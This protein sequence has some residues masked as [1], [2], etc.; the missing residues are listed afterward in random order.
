[1][2]NKYLKK[3]LFWLLI[4]FSISCNN[5][6]KDEITYEVKNYGIEYIVASPIM[7]TST[8]KNIKEKTIKNL[9]IFEVKYIDKNDSITNNFALIPDIEQPLI[10]RV[11][12]TFDNSKKEMYKFSKPYSNNHQLKKDISGEAGNVSQEIKDINFEKSFFE[13]ERRFDKI[14]YFEKI[15]NLITNGDKSTFFL[16]FSKDSGSFLDSKN[17]IHKIYNDWDLISSLRDSIVCNTNVEKPKI[18]ILVDILDTTIKEKKNP[19]PAQADKKEEKEEKE[20]KTKSKKEVGKQSP[21][22]NKKK[23]SGSRYFNPEDGSFTFTIDDNLPYTNDDIFGQVEISLD[24][25]FSNIYQRFEIK[26][27]SDKKTLIFPKNLSD[28]KKMKKFPAPLY[29][30]YVIDVLDED[31]SYSGNFKYY[32]YP[33]PVEVLC[34]ADGDCHLT[35]YESK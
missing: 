30:R 7:D 14:K 18:K 9:S 21:V 20:E 19:P 35:N 26:K 32:D 17:N 3:L 25:S 34:F 1:M 15:N 2:T 10:T 29:I 24:K 6:Q 31:G 22:A 8:L 16:F 11:L 13:K 28:A 5:S 33:N 4:F 23:L 12:S 27:S